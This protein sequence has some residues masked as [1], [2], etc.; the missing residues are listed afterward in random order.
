MLYLIAILYRI[1]IEEANQT[2]R[3]PKFEPIWASNDRNNADL[4]SLSLAVTSVPN[5]ENSGFFFNK[6]PEFFIK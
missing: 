1:A 3:L 2:D 6:K 5:G 4:P